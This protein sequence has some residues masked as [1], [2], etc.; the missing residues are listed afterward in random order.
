MVKFLAG[1]V[2]ALCLLAVA[3]YLFLVG[4]G[5]PVATTGSALPLERWVARTAI[6]AAIKGD[7][8]QQSPVVLTEPALMQGARDYSNHCAGC[9]GLPEHPSTEF[10]KAMY[11]HPP[12][13][14]EPDEGVTDDPVGAVHWVIHNG[15]RM[16]GMPGFADLLKEDQ[17]WQISLL[18]KNSDKLPKE[19]RAELIQAGRH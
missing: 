5:M 7:A 12:Q 16:T 9:H 13:L 1:F 2:T 18:L 14:F 17:I 10:A 11:P 15:I 4:G 3:A 8:G 6:R 19:V